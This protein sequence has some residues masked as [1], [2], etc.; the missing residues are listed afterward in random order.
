MTGPFRHRLK[1]SIQL[2]LHTHLISNHCSL[3]QDFVVK[4]GTETFKK[5]QNWHK[6]KVIFVKQEQIYANLL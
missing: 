5:F 2:P 1:C 6:K 4:T 3:R